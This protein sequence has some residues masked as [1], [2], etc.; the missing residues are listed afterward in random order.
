MVL[1][2]LRRRDRGL[3][4]LRRAGRTAI[5]MPSMFAIADLV[6]G[7]PT[8]AAFAAFGSFASLLLFDPPGPT[9]A[10]LRAQ[11]ALAVA[12]AVLVCLGTLAEQSAVSA[13]VATAIVAFGIIFSGVVSSLLAG[14]TTSLLLAFILSVCLPGPVSSIPDRLA[15]WGLA[16]AGALLAVALLWPAPARDPVRS[17]AIAACRA[18]GARL[19]TEVAHRLGEA[20]RP[21]DADYAAA[22]AEADARVAALHDVFY[23]T[24][25]R[26]TGLST[27]ARTVVRLVDELQWM[28]GVLVH[29]ASPAG[30]RVDRSV[31]EVKL[32]AAAVL[33]R[34]AELLD[35]PR[36][37]PAELRAALDDLQERVAELERDARRRLVLSSVDPS[38]R[39]QELSFV[40]E[41]V[42][43]NIDLAAAAERRS[44]LAQ[45]MGREPTDV[46]GTL[47]SAQERAGAHVERHSLWLQ[48]SV[49]GAV[50]LGI[51]VLIADATDVSHGFWVVLGTLSVLRSN[52]LSTGQDVLRALLGTAVGFVL[53]AGIVAAVGTD[54]TLL[55]V[56]LPFAVL[57]AGLAPAT[58]SFAAG[59]AAFT[60]TVLIVFNILAPEGW[61]IGL[62]RIEDVA[63]GCAV[64]VVVGLLFWP[65]G[66]AAALSTALADAYRDS[67]RYLAA[68][69]RFGLGRCDAGTPPEP[70]PTELAGR[71][72]AA[73]RRLD[74]AFR[75][76]LAERGAKP[77]PLAEVTSLLAGVIGLRLAGDA[78][79]DVWAG[80]GI[81]GG[82]RAAARRELLATSDEV[83]AWYEAF[84]AGLTDHGVVP[85]PLPDDATASERLVAA[86]GED[87][88]AA[89]AETGATAVRVLWTGD[90]LDAARRLQAMVAGPAREA[91][92]AR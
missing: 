88:L 18:L 51:A 20:D 58:A 13:A 72:A 85:E 17:A 2:W 11:L 12:G 59:Q 34:G 84:A 48:N 9:R 61:K 64:S 83:S 47:A 41:A 62:V 78:V 28:N 73:S 8:T 70:A 23:A 25:Y 71:A 27:A 15:G 5:V 90:H 75:T 10:R 67:S 56:L 43:R 33:E 6:I 3:V 19:R 38:F 54:T 91:V 50:G 82:D 29:A 46:R 42:G 65:R 22:V 66:A 32:A 7:D 60:L 92:G 86:V 77:V 4:A 24:P 76:Y 89:D 52:A 49:R 37:S 31:C 1:T 63:L 53:G 16:S 68:A 87:L 30:V 57:L 35:A 39:A 21:S 79:L 26:P 36:R 14:A 45:L 55:W 80:D 40:V 44:W 69:V 81:A 74:D